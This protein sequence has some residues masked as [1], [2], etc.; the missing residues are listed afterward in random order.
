MVMTTEVMM[1]MMKTANDVITP[2]TNSNNGSHP[3]SIN[4][5]STLLQQATL[6]VI[7]A[8]KRKAGVTDS[9]RLNFVMSDGVTVV[10]CR[11][12]W[13]KGQ[14][15][16]SMYYN[17]GTA[18]QRVRSATRAV[19]SSNCARSSSVKGEWTHDKKQQHHMMTMHSQL[20][21]CTL[22]HNKRKQTA[23]KSNTPSTNSNTLKHTR[24]Y[25]NK[26]R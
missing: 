26:Y 9:S 2:K 5:W 15:A 14:V 3:S 19:A 1:M 18:F 8:E 24:P 13:P 12:V 11:Y 10:A 6:N 16:A 4:C 21:C 22:E 23:T 20:H 25:S 7:M 17:E